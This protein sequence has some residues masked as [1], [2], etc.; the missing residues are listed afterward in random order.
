METTTSKITLTLEGNEFKGNMGVSGGAV[1]C[2]NCEY[3]V[4]SVP[5][6]ARNIFTLNYARHGGDIFIHN[7]LNTMNTFSY[8]KINGHSHTSSVAKTSGGAIYIKEEN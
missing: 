7:I 8:F 5:G 6:V 2:K 4:G 1:F 3:L